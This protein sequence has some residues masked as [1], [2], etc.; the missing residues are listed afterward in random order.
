M[1]KFWNTIVVYIKRLLHSYKVNLVVSL[2]SAADAAC[3]SMDR[4]IY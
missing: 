2:I 3:Y 4:Y 1:I